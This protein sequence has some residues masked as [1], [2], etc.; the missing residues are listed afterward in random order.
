M[1]LKIKKHTHRNLVAVTRIHQG[2]FLITCSEESTSGNV[3]TQFIGGPGNMS[4]RVERHI[5]R[6]PFK[7]TFS[8]FEYTT[9]HIPVHNT[10]G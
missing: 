2:V 6:Y 1:F 5:H 10:Y 4:K 3:Y 8:V 7:I 9:V